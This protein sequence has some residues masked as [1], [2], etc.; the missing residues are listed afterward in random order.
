VTPE[1]W[2]Q[3]KAILDEAGPL[4][5]EFRAQALD[6]LCASDVALRQEAEVYLL[7]GDK[8]GTDFLETPAWR[9]LE[10][11]DDPAEWSGRRI[12]VY[13]LT[14][15]I[16]HGG[17]GDV[18]RAFRADDQY[19]KLVAIKLIRS[20]Q[21]SSFILRRFLTERQI[22]AN[23]EHPNIARLLDGGT[24]EDGVPFFVMELI[25]G[26]RIDVFCD[27]RK[28]PVV[29]RLRM[30]LQV[31]SAVQ[32]AHQSLIVHR[33]IK[34]GNVLVTSDG[35]PKLL[36]FGI[37]TL[38]SEEGASALTAS[39]PNFIERQHRYQRTDNNEICFSRR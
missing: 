36:D 32:Y 34:P 21:H 14:D 30:F 12:G 5:G 8:A 23:L 37:A 6:R 29:E 2:Q 24:T 13:E 1:R 3:I 9:T 4:Q 15:L 26:H 27:D 39:G 7:A 25:E 18:Y 20:D 31:C 33:D 22:L 10:A 11:S 17:M 28:L 35:T 38:L 19:K 16:G